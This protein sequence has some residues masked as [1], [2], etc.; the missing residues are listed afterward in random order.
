MPICTPTFSLARLGA[1]KLICES[2]MCRHTS[3]ASTA[4]RLKNSPQL[5]VS[6]DVVKH[7]GRMQTGMVTRMSKLVS[8]VTQDAIARSAERLLVQAAMA[9]SAGES[10]T[11]GSPHPKDFVPSWMLLASRVVF[12]LSAIARRALHTRLRQTLIGPV[13]LG[14]WRCT[15]PLSVS[16]FGLRDF[17]RS[18]ESPTR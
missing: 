8:K 2:S 12:F 6:A 10:F 7:A 16:G 11:R 9:S 17:G 3:L 1:R 5:R 18:V 4:C 13:S 15:S 14:S